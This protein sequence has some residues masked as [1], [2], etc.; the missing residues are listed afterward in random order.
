M[1]LE[2]VKL[3]ESHKSFN[4]YQNKYSHYSKVLKC[5]MKFELYLPETDDL[6]PLI[7]FLSGL[8]CD[9]TNFTHKSGFQRLASQYKLA[10]IIPDTSPRGENVADGDSW[11]IGLGAGFYM[12]TTEEPW[13]K[14]YQMYDYITKELPMIVKELIPNFN[15][16]EAMMGHSMGGYGAL[17]VGM[18]D[19]ERFTSISAFAPIT[20]PTQIP[21]G[22]KIF[23]SYLGDNQ[24]D[25]KPWD[26]VNLVG[27]DMTY[28]PIYITQGTADN[29]YEDQL[30]ED[31]FLTA[32]KHQ[33]IRY[34]KKEGYDHGYYFIATFLE[35]HIQFH[36]NNL[37][38]P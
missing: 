38:N 16:K 6:V 10:F 35:E 5:A 3:E 22:Q 20:N 1:T 33:N 2:T 29:F 4:G 11:D 37:I 15:G 26:T 28:P 13:Q 12:N 18:R 23:S 19:H 31:A 9:E 14:H 36:L 27:K 25:W 24:T 34:E 21:W 7:W 8:T 30:N 17:L 32:G